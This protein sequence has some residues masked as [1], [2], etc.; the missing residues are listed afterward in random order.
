MKFKN[1]LLLI[2][3]TAITGTSSAIF[4]IEKVDA[5]LI[6]P[7][8]RCRPIYNIDFSAPTHQNGQLPAVGTG[9]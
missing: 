7:L 4:P 3:G 9:L 1:I 5:Q 6:K 8:N 2:L